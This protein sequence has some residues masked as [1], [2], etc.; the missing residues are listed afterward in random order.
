MI[1]ICVACAGRVFVF[2][3]ELGCERCGQRWPT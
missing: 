1:G 2:D 3:A